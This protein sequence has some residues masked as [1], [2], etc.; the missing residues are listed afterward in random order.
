MTPR[1][2]QTVFPSLPAGT[3]PAGSRRLRVC[4]ASCEF[5][6]PIRNGGIG[7]AYTA[8]AHALVAAG[9]EVTLFYTQGLHCENDNVNHWKIF[10]QKQG[11]KFVARPSD[12]DLRIDAPDLATRSY[13]T[14]RWLKTQNFDLVHFPEWSGDAYYSLMAKNQ[15]LE[16][17]KTLF[18]IG[19]HSPNAWLKQAN[20][21]YYA[22]PLDLEVD[23]M[24]RRCVALADIVVSPCQYMLHWMTENGFELPARSY[25]QQNI[26][27]ARARGS[28]NQPV[29]RNPADGFREIVFFGRL[30]NAQG[31]IELF[32]DALDKLVAEPALKNV[33]I[34]FLGKPAT[35]N[36]VESRAYIQKRSQK[37]PWQLGLV[38][39]QDQPGAMRYLKQPGR[40]AVMP[41][42]MENSPYTVL[43][44]L[45]SRIPFL[46]SRVGGIPELIAD[47]DVPHATFIPSPVELSKLLAQT[48][49]DGVR[50]WKPSVESTANETAWINWHVGI[51]AECI[52][53]EKQ[54]CQCPAGNSELP[55]VTVCIPTHFNR[56]QFFAAGARF[57]WRSA[58][59][60]KFL[61]SSSSMTAAQSWRP[62]QYLAEIEPK[63]LQPELAHR[64][65]GKQIS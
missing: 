35:V 57:R 29:S 51:Q 34:T 7:T 59:L 22:H 41:S 5:I 6:G 12:P 63:L 48:L 54:P 28:D 40:L 19:T 18:C 25:V 8:M 53:A 39:D 45:N 52:A 14:Y 37:W 23:F 24:E 61:K 21:D 26:L 1:E 3:V 11:F 50:S 13:E 15:G 36:R 42:L 33:R 16:F 44:C 46:A 62:S 10:Y 55:M 9:H 58:G 20:S 56:P 65:S 27:P 31:R 47:S 64:S 2:S 32:C 30:G 60:S 17:Q 4:I 49:R 43:E 38:I